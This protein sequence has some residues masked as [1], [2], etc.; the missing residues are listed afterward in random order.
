[1]QKLTS[2]APDVTEQMFYAE[3]ASK[4]IIRQGSQP[5][6]QMYAEKEQRVQDEI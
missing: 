1:M 6:K 5:C 3:P 4:T 2:L